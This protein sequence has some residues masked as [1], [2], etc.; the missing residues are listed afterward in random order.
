[1]ADKKEYLIKKGAYFYRHNSQGYTN[2]KFD[3][4]RY[5]KAEAEKEA[6]IEPWHMQAIHQDDVPEE[7]AP[8]KA[9][10]EMA[11]T[12]EHWRHEVG[13]L[14]S[15]LATKDEQIARLK[16]AINWCIERDDRN[17]SLPEAYR[18]KLTE[19]NGY[20]R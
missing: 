13:K 1:M 15:Q 2:F 8:E 4:G 10:S 3:A 9:F 18:H 20:Y 16:A 5:T 14:H 12:L 11:K 17:G 6:A 7:S 19:A